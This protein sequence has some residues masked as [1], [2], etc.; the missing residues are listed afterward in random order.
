M[1]ATWNREQVVREG[2]LLANSADKPV[3]VS[4]SFCVQTLLINLFVSLVCE[5]NTGAPETSRHDSEHIPNTFMCTST[6]VCS[7]YLITLSNAFS[8]I[9]LTSLYVCLC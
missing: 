7:V 3:C 1:I 6:F 9:E 2:D 8:V 4:V 5:L